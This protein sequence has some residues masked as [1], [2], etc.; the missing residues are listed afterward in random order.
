[1]GTTI[2]RGTGN[3]PY[4][5]YDKAETVSKAGVETITGQK[6]FTAPVKVADATLAD[7][8]LSKGQLLTEMKAVDGSGSGLDA[9]LLDGKDSAEFALSSNIVSKNF[10][11]QYLQSIS[12]ANGDIEVGGA[13][14]FTLSIIPKNNNSKFKIYARHFGE[15]INAQD[16]V[17][18]VKRNGVR[19]NVNGDNSLW[20]GLSMPCQTYGAGAND[21]STPEIME[22]TTIDTPNVVAGTTLTYTL[23]M[24]RSSTVVYNTYTNRCFAGTGAINVETGTSEF[25]IEEIL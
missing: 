7:E 23:V 17:F 11:T 24:A 15:S 13:G 5:V 4:D 19:I 2:G 1:M 12:S 3:R 6:T 14:V 22:L 8:A 16:L 21:S 9:D 18:N 20:R 10:T 25:I